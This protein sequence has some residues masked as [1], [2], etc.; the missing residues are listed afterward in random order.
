M[1][2]ESVFLLIAQ[3]ARFRQFRH[4]SLD[5]AD[6]FRIEADREDVGLREE[7]VVDVAFLLAHQHRRLRRFVKAP[8][9]LLH[10]AAGFQDLLL[11]ADF[12]IN[13]LADIGDGIQVLD[14]ILGAQMR[15]AFRLDGD[16]DVA[17]HGR[18]W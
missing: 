13:R 4:R 3:L 12:V 1:V 10:A 16:V 15:G 7:L 2:A 11:P 18:P 9:L 17:A 14:L 8:G 6:P 5:L